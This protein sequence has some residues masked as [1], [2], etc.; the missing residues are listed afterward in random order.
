M[1]EV[2]EKFRHL[3]FSHPDPIIPR[4]KKY[5]T[6]I[7]PHGQKDISMASFRKKR[8]AGIS[9]TLLTVRPRIFFSPTYSLRLFEASLFVK[10]LSG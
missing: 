2:L 4:R 6:N 3:F 8:R 9:S 5:K 10:S 1:S 7:Y